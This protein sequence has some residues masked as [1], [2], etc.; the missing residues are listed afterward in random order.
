MYTAVRV[1]YLS[2]GRTARISGQDVNVTYSWI[3]LVAEFFL[4]CCGVY[5]NQLF[6]KQET[7]FTRLTAKEYDE[8]EKV[9]LR[10]PWVARGLCVRGYV[11]LC[12]HCSRDGVPYFAPMF[13]HGPMF[14]RGVC[15]VVLRSACG[16]LQ[17]CGIHSSQLAAVACVVQRCAQHWRM[18]PQVSVWVPIPAYRLL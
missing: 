18:A 13:L 10:S 5:S 8:L 15:S 12:E 16:V 14:A 11:G 9:R 3:I 7:D 1:W 6:W 17:W 4:T 2:T